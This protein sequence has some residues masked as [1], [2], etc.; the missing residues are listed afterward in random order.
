MAN[1]V[2]FVQNEFVAKNEFPAFQSGDTITVYYEIKE[3]SKTR[4]QFFRGVV[5]KEEVLEHQKLLQL[6]KCLVLLVWSVSSQ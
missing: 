5:S 3:G 1:L 2:D 4:T 6:E